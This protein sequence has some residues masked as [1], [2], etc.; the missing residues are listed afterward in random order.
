MAKLF[1]DL[2]LFLSILPEDMELRIAKPA[3]IRIDHSLHQGIY[4]CV[5]LDFPKLTRMLPETRAILGGNL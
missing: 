2:S 3:D 4:S 5:F 1:K